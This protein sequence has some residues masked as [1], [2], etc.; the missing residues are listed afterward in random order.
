MIQHV[1]VFGDSLS[2]GCWDSE[3]G[4]VDR[5]RKYLYQRFSDKMK[6]GRVVYNLSKSGG[7]SEGLLKKFDYEMKAYNYPRPHKKPII[8]IATGLNDIHSK[9]EGG[10]LEFSEEEFERIIQSLVKK[11][12]DIT[13]RTYVLGLTLVAES[14]MPWIPEF[15]I[16]NDDAKNYD[17]IIKNV[18]K[19]ENVDFIDVFSKFRNNHLNLLDDGLHP[20]TEG[21]K[22]IF[23]IVRDY[24]EKNK[25]I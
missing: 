3:G 20:N 16:T 4:W 13:S 11:A 6:D 15:Y 17:E 5:L 24:L 21:H 1:F 8:F 23:E 10:K 12:K 2:A 9:E 25:V 19:K 18:C 14:T 7:F 22:L